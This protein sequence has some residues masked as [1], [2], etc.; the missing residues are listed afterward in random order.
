MGRST[1]ERS[2]RGSISS[3]R[4]TACPITVAGSK[5]GG[6]AIFPRY[7]SSTMTCTSAHRL[8]AEHLRRPPPMV[9]PTVEGV[10]TILI[11][12]KP[13]YARMIERGERGVEFRRRFPG[14][15]SRG[16]ALFYLSSPLR[17]IAMTAR[18]V[19]VER[20]TPRTLWRQFADV[21]GT[22]RAEFD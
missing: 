12:I 4:Q 1:S 2:S 13:H 16:C 3:P 5:F 8:L 14:G 20:A 7:N 11:S 15:I 21:A 10:A 22:R 19:R 9:G 6:N 18:I 17:Q